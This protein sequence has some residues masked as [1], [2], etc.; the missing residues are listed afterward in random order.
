MHIELRLHLFDLIFDFLVALLEAL[1]LVSLITVLPKTLHLV[2]LEVLVLRYQK[3]SIVFVRIACLA[4]LGHD[5]L[6]LLV[7]S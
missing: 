6:G 2:R 3:V 7:E 5:D 1:Q 4:V